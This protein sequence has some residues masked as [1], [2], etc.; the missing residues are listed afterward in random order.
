MVT[1]PKCHKNNIVMEQPSWLH[2]DNPEDEFIE[3]QSFC[4][5]CGVNFTTKHK[6]GRVLKV[7]DIEEDVIYPYAA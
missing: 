4:C 5:D 1:C 7:Y 2:T 6:L 3:V